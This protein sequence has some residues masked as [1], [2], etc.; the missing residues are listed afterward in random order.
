MAV[1]GEVDV[2]VVGGG[3]I[4]LAIAWRTAQRGLS[5]TVVDP[6]PGAGASGTAA[7]MLAPVTEAH[8]TERGLLDLSL[9]SAARYPRFVEELEAATGRDV[10]Y[11]R[12]GT[13]SVAWD[14][15]D[16]AA[17]NDLHNFQQSLGLDVELLTGFELRR[18]EPHLSPGLPGGVLTGTDHQ[19]DPGELVAALMAAGAAAGVRRCPQR[20]RRVVV[21]RDRAIGARLDDGQVVGADRTVVATGAWSRLDGIP[22]GVM[23]AVR[24]IKGQ[25]VR[26]RG[27]PGVLR[28]VVRGSVRGAPVYLVPRADGRVVLGASSE[29]AGFDL[30][31]RA[32]AVYELLRDAQALVPAVAEMELTDLR[33]SLRPGTPDNAPLV[34]P[35]SLEG[36]VVA[37]GHY[38]NGVLLAPVTA[39]GV[40]TLLADGS[41][42]AGWS[43]FDPGRFPCS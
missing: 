21:E 35:T 40:A 27:E 36:L 16:L 11:R 34:G 33:T 5:V 10:G 18:L 13:V 42:P 37:T 22:P 7:G 19:V 15:A 4:G 31:T 41:L 17:L 8:Y 43:C 20:V 28:H 24:P 23:P 1:T 6:E 32:G 26:L 9:D 38:R 12:C 2:L 29:E 14:A 39:D 25:T 3:V 30:R